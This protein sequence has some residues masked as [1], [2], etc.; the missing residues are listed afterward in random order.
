MHFYYLQQFDKNESYVSVGFSAFPHLITITP[1]SNTIAIDKR[2]LETG[3]M[4]I[5]RV[6]TNFN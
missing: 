5:D 6:R 2:E 4:S 1:T 3:E